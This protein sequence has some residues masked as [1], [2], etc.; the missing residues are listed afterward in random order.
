MNKFD[1]VDEYIVS[2]PESMQMI[3][4]K[5]RSIIKKN[6]RD[7]SEQISYGMPGYK[8][9]GKPLVYFGGFSNHIGF[10]PVPSGI[11]AFKT[12]LSHYASGKG[13]VQFPLDQ[14]IPYALIQKIVEY[15]V[16]E[17]SQK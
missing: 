3:L 2:F 7:A 16:K 5:I 9:G 8:L 6:A 11:A 12:E 17:V 15:R 13:S 14:E 10:Y 4:T 1:S